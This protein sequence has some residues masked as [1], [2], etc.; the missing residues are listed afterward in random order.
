[1]ESKLNYTTES[2]NLSDSDSDS[3]KEYISDSIINTNSINIL[4]KLELE[5][6]PEPF[7]TI[8][9]ILLSAISGASVAYIMNIRSNKYHSYYEY[10]NTYFDYCKNVE[11]DNYIN[12]ILINLKLDKENDLTKKNKFFS[13]LN[14]L[15][16]KL[17]D[18]LISNN[19]ETYAKYSL[20]TETEFS[21]ESF[22]AEVIRDLLKLIKFSE[23]VDLI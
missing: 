12:E 3:D 23:L 21:I 5:Y 8:G 13:D 10:L 2:F 15:S 14:E 6:F 22:N 19:K 17:M 18:E 20:V 9:Q 1:M 4:D 16:K 7:N 11:T